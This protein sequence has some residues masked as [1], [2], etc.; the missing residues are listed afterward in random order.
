MAIVILRKEEMQKEKRHGKAMVKEKK[1]K[2]RDS[3]SETRYIRST[4]GKGLAVVDPPPS[5]NK[6][7]VDR[8]FRKNNGSKGLGV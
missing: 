4:D 2:P 5:T 1:N 8:F 7:G 3:P 6:F